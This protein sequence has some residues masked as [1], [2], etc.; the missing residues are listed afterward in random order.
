MNKENINF[1]WLDISKFLTITLTMHIL[2]VLVDD[3]GE[4]FSELALKFFLYLILGLLIYYFIVK[5]WLV[6]LLTKPT[7]KTKKMKKQIKE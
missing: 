7:K 4:L 1:M 3:Q 5:V 2:Y 6:K